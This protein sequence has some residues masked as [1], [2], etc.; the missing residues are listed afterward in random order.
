MTVSPPLFVLTCDG[1]D[2]CEL[3]LRQ[4]TEAEQYA[5]MLEIARMIRKRK[6]EN[7]AAA[8]ALAHGETP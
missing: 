7:A 5:V 2:L 8:L 1:P 4:P 3:A 6:I